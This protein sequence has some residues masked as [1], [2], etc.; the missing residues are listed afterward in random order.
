[1]CAARAK[2]P[3]PG[4]GTLTLVPPDPLRDLIPSFERGAAMQRAVREF[5]ERMRAWDD[6]FGIR[7][8]PSDLR[9]LDGFAQAVYKSDMAHLAATVRELDRLARAHA[10]HRLG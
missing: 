7:R 10:E 6:L 9:L 5:C 8:L 3:R 4:P 1:V 2:N